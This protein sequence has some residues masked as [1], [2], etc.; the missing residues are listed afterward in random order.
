MDSREE[1]SHV[2][3]GDG[4]RRDKVM[5]DIRMHSPHNVDIYAGQSKLSSDVK[6]SDLVH[7]FGLLSVGPIWSNYC[8]IFGAVA[9]LE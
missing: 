6:E 3:R 8:T 1:G 5:G 4:V 2:W 9:T 7:H